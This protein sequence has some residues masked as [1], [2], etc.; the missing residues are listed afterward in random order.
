MPRNR[1]VTLAARPAGEPQESD[2]AILE[3]EAPS[4]GDGEGVVR[5]L[6][7]AL[8]PYMRGRM[9]EARSYAAPVDLGGVMTA[10][11][12]G[13]VVESRSPRFAPGDVVLGGFGWQEYAVA[14]AHH[15]RRLD[16]SV[17]PVST[18]L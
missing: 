15:L 12:V 8:D 6:W 3:A 16:P 9:N 17:A 7:L 11:G 2:F 1:Q 14:P 10:Q 13:E 4:P 5:V 18:A